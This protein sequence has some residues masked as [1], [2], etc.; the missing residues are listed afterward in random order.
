[1]ARGAKAAKDTPSPA[2]TGTPTPASTPPQ[3]QA[4]VGVDPDARIGGVREPESDLPTDLGA[5]GVEMSEAVV[6]SSRGPA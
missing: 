1:V 4:V 5:R 3:P 2:A 6:S